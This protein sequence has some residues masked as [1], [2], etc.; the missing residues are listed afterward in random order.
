MEGEGDA[1]WSAFREFLTGGDRDLQ[2]LAERLGKSRG[3]L[4]NYSSKYTWAAR[5]AAWDAAQVE[6]EDAAILDERGNLAR[7]HLRAW[8]RV[9][10]IALKHLEKLVNKKGDADGEVKPGDVAKLL[11][12]ATHYERLIMGEATERQEVRGDLDLA[13]LSLE[14]LRVLKDL[15]AKAAR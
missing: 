12:R 7:E 3:V 11:D 6:A 2:T 13:K 8:K 14:D 5:A 10:E 4:K 9:R 1:P 15:T